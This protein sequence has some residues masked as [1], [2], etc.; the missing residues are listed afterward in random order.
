MN[1]N[2][3]LREK[4]FR[5]VRRV[6]ARVFGTAR[7]PRLAVFRSNRFLYAQLIDDETSRTLVAAS[8]RDSL[9]GQKGKSKTDAA[10]AVGF[11]LAEKA[12][13]ANIERAVFDRR[14]YAYHGRVKALREGAQKGG[15]RV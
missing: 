9:H 12:R 5:R 11:A 8:S 6:R 4:R 7:E 2:R 15:L 14:S 13:Q 10:Y 3:S 1:T